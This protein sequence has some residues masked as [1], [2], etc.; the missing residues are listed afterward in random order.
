MGRRF[1]QAAQLEPS[2]WWGMLARQSM[3]SFL[4]EQS[5]PKKFIG[6]GLLG[7]ILLAC[8]EAQENKLPEHTVDVSSLAPKTGK[9][10]QISVSAKIARSQC[11]DLIEHYRSEGKPDGQISVHMPSA[12]LGGQVLPWCL[13]NFDGGGVQFNDYFFQ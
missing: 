9:R 5:S 10:I 12:K 2:D 1:P 3:I 4:R 8:S 7:L 11:S 6:V 13:E